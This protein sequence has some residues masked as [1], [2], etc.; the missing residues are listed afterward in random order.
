M[1]DEAAVVLSAS[2][3][4]ST[5]VLKAV[6]SL[7]QLQAALGDITKASRSLTDSASSGVGATRAL[8]GASEASIVPH[9]A[10]HKTLGLVSQSMAQ[11]SEA[12]PAAQ[13]G[14]RVLDSVLFQMVATGG[15]VSL[16]FVGIAAAAVGAGVAMRSAAE[17]AKKE[18]EELDK[19]TASAIKAV[20]A[21]NYLDSAQKSVAGV[22]GAQLQ[23]RL[24]QLKGQIGDLTQ[25]MNENADAAKRGVLPT[26]GATMLAGMKDALTM[27]T[28]GAKDT[29][30]ASQQKMAGELRI[31]QEEFKKTQH[32][33]D[34]TTK[35]ASIYHST[36]QDTSDPIHEFAAGLDLSAAET[37]KVGVA[38]GNVNASMDVVI[39]NAQQLGVDYTQAAT[40]MRAQNEAVK[41]GVL[42]VAMAIGV[43]LGNSISGAKDA[44]KE[45]LKAMIS[46]V[47]D[48]ATQVVIAAS[49]MNEAISMALIPGTF[50]G[51]LALVAVL[52]AMKMVAVSAF[53]SASASAA[54]SAQAAVGP[55]SAAPGIPSTGGMAGAPSGPGG[56]AVSSAQK[57]VVNNISVTLPVHALDL[58]SISDIQMNNLATRVGRIIAEAAGRGQFSLVGA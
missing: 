9:N 12:S 14:V 50:I 36:L 2:D 49:I 51:I 29:G 25:K 52:Q 39:A 7:Q 30:A 54:S 15:A 28:G 16:G 45:G 26:F 11:L 17:S 53:T 38:L 58:A 10:A 40:I 23:Q 1:A 33:I 20:T 48:A 24:I 37:E 56:T 3:Q 4:I 18:Q 43:A 6:A 55:V 22:G 32:Q 35:K 47:F 31:L 34:E 13:A 41:N 5:P 21:L 27:S 8:A 42:N 46:A 19:M 44:W 57:E